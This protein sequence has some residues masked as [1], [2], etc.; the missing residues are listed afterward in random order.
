MPT[1]EYRCNKC[2]EEFSRIMSLREYESAK[3]PCPKCGSEDIV[4]QMSTFMPRTSRK[5]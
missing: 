1:Y 3:I 4:Q 5:S 2:G